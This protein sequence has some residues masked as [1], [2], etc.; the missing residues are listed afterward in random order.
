MNSEDLG[1]IEDFLSSPVKICTIALDER[2]LKKIPNLR[3]RIAYEQYNSSDMK[4]QVTQAYVDLKIRNS[5]VYLTLKGKARELEE[6]NP[7]LGSGFIYNLIF[8]KM[9]KDPQSVQFQGSLDV[10]DFV[11]IYEIS[12]R[13]SR[14]YLND[15]QFNL[16]YKA[17][18]E[19]GTQRPDSN[20]TSYIAISGWL[21]KIILNGSTTLFNKYYGM[22][23][24]EEALLEEND[25]KKEELVREQQRFLS[26]KKHDYYLLERDY[27]YMSEFMLASKKKN[28][29]RR[30]V[31][32]LR[33]ELGFSLTEGTVQSNT[34][35]KIFDK[36]KEKD[37]ELEF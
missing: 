24:C 4:E 32:L 35:K 36:R 20:E 11:K 12:A 2:D 6:I 30:D 22:Y 33:E 31:S 37:L 18:I 3:N 16:I 13:H 9:T 7:F 28:I 25:L 15:D 34:F 23:C 19:M 26:D 27:E 10:R 21:E 29:V 5:D 8:E 1:K 14:Q 17:M